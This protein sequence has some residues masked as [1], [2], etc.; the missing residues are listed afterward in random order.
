MDVRIVAATNQNLSTKMA[1]GAFRED[2]FFRLERFTVT[3][4]PLRERKEDISLL[5]EHFLRMFSAEMGIP[6]PALSSEALKTLEFYSFPGNVRELKNI[7]E[8]ALLKSS[9]GSVI[10]PVHLHFIDLSGEPS[11]KSKGETD[12]ID[13]PP[14]LEQAESRLIEYALQQTGD[15]IAAAARMIGTSRPKI[16]RYLVKK[17]RAISNQ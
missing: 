10:K 17:G 14:N 4:P 11:T 15:N 13:V 5:A 6:Q 2:L 12:T 3:V 8:R 9:G 16:Y 1:E 7:I